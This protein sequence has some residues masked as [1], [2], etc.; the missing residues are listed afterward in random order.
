MLF[1]SEHDLSLINGNIIYYCP[2]FLKKNCEIKI[3]N[4]DYSMLYEQAKS[5]IDKEVRSNIKK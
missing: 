4:E 1:R 5:Y 3:D 2:E